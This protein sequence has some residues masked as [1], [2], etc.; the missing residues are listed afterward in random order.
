MKEKKKRKEK[1]L[2]LQNNKNKCKYCVK[3]ANDGFW[4]FFELVSY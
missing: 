2:N 4:V 1:N 3:K